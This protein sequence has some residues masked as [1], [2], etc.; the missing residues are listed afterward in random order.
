MDIFG[1]LM[2]LNMQKEV[3]TLLVMG[4][5]Q[6]SLNVSDTIRNHW[7]KLWIFP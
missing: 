1:K 5:R 6:N 3:R 4:E 2:S 7:V